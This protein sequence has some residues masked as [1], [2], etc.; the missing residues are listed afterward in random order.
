MITLSKDLEVGVP[1]IDEQHREL[2]N[3]LN[4]VTEMGID[5]VSREETKKTLDFLGDYVVKHFGDEE[6]LQKKSGYPKYE[7]HKEQHKLFIDNFKKLKEEFITNGAS[8]KY[9]MDL[10]NSIITWIV[11]HI[12][13]ADVELGKYISSR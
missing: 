8:L 12:K 10:N 4:Q 1:E 2:V 6:A 7:W 9:T 5:A 13:T 11:R 3:R